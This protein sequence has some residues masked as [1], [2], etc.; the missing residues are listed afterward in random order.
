MKLGLICALAGVAVLPAAA[1]A[2]FLDGFESY[3][4]GSNLHGQGGWKGWDNDPAH[5]GT[6]S[7]A[8]AHTGTKSA[9]ITTPSASTYGDD[10]TH[11]FAGVNA[12]VWTFTA[13][14]Y[15][16]G[17]TPSGAGRNT[18][19]I[20][21]NT[22]TDGGDSTV[23]RWSLQLKFDLATTGA[24]AN[25][26]YDDTLAAAGSPGTNFVPIVRDAWVP[27]QVVI[28]LGADT[29]NASYNGSTVI[30]TTWRRGTA[31]ANLTI[32]AVDLYSSTTG[33]VYYDDLALVPAPAGASLLALAG[34]IAGRRR[35]A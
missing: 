1:M 29:M 20:L 11:E 10:L 14:Q 21:M 31:G 3:A 2:D 12:G 22:Y 28:D 35:R 30:S 5:A 18:Y 26:V 25:R 16:P 34:L 15:I 27:I 17:N 19:L 33:P 8:F 23:D 7:S 32:Q 6:A 24:T 13:W 4:A 9:A